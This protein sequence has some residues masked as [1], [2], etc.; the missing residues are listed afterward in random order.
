MSAWRGGG[1]RDQLCYP[2]L[3]HGA[4]LST[5]S[6]GKQLVWQTLASR[7]ETAF[8]VTL[9]EIGQAHYFSH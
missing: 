3:L 6:T 5:I 8:R 7:W 1:I 4:Q 9:Q 2:Q